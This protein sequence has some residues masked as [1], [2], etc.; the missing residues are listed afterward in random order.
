MG[1][2]LDDDYTLENDSNQWVLIYKK[3][4]G[5]SNKTNKEYFT[6][7]KWYCS[8]LENALKRYMDES[9]KPCITVNH[10]MLKMDDVLTNIKNVKWK[11]K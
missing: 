11:K 9:L 1:I 8:S 2:K 6:Q 4:K 10:L 5:L 7:N 3:S